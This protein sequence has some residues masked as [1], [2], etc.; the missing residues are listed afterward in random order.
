MFS[1]VRYLLTLSILVCL[2]PSLKAS[3]PE[4]YDIVSLPHVALS[5]FTLE[6]LGQKTGS[7]EAFA[8]HMESWMRFPLGALYDLYEKDELLLVFSGGELAGLPVIEFMKAFA[9]F[10]KSYCFSNEDLSCTRQMWN[11]GSRTLA[12]SH[13]T[14]FVPKNEFRFVGHDDPKNPVAVKLIPPLSHATI[15]SLTLVHLRAY[16]LAG[17]DMPQ[18]NLLNLAYNNLRYIPGLANFNHLCD[19]DLSYNQFTTLEGPLPGTLRRLNLAHNRFKKIPSHVSTLAGLSQ[20]DVHE[21]QIADFTNLP[22]FLE[23]LVMSR[24]P[25]KR[26]GVLPILLNDLRFS[27]AQWAMPEFQ[28]AVKQ[29]YVKQTLLNAISKRQWGHLPGLFVTENGQSLRLSPQEIRAIRSQSPIKELTDF[30]LINLVPLNF[31]E[32]QNQ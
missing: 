24:N 6:H 17:L 11:F 22:P 16:S 9:E 26:V 20:L 7:A 5:D 15:R 2:S 3:E 23:S 8:Q 19:L 4:E 12:T 21:N 29:L 18:L 13:M 32:P 31:R 1:L 10:E 28:T 14:H 25:L 30:D 27:D